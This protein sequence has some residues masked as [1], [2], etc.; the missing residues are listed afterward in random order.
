MY[1]Y[2]SEGHGPGQP[3][4][5]WTLAP[6]PIWLWRNARPS[7]E[8]DVAQLGL[9]PR[10]QPWVTLYALPRGTSVVVADRAIQGWIPP[11]DM[12]EPL[13]IAVPGFW[14]GA[15]VGAEGRRSWQKRVSTVTLIIAKFCSEAAG[16][17]P[18]LVHFVSS[19]MLLV[20]IHQQVVVLSSLC[21]GVA[22]MQSCGSHLAQLHIC[23]GS[24]LGHL[25]PVSLAGE[26][27]GV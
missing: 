7:P 3:E 17:D 26:A 12:M 1:L 2:C 11:G 18:V 9:K 20:P 16:A 13:E 24:N 6:T 22:E 8:P 23:Q 5:L 15:P 25:A 14:W 21:I 10:L 4:A 19:H 27:R